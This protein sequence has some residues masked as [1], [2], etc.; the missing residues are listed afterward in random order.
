MKQKLTVIILV[1]TFG[2]V[3]S[4]IASYYT[5]SSIYYAQE[6]SLV[7]S[8][9]YDL[10]YVID[11]LDEL[12]KFEAIDPIIQEKLETILVSSLVTLRARNPDLTDLQGTPKNTLCRIIKYNRDVE[13]AKNGIGRY[14]DADIPK[15]VNSYLNKIKPE[16]REIAENSSISFFEC[17]ELFGI[18]N[19]YKILK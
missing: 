17:N 12:K 2:V 5:A 11:A 6:I 1:V 4:A 13:I 10:S 3:C 7:N 9:L 18:T 19:K 8:T 14:Q 16:L 15:M